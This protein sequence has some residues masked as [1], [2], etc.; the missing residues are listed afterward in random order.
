MTNALPY[1][2]LHASHSGIWIC[3]VDGE[4]RAI[5]KGEAIGRVAE[6]PHI[7]LN[8]PL[9]GQRL[10]YPDLS[11]LDLLELFAFIHP[12]QFIGLTPP[13]Q[14]AD[15]AALYR[16]AATLLLEGLK[17]P[18][19]KEREGAWSSAQALYRLR[20]PWAQEVG[21]QL[22]KPAQAERW[23]FS[24]LDE[25]EEEAPR[26]APRSITVDKQETLATLDALTGEGSEERQGQKNYAAAVTQIFNPR[27]IKGAPNMLLPG[28]PGHLS[29][30]RDIPQES[31]RAQGTGKLSLPAQSRRR[32][33]GRFCGKSGDPCPSGRALGGL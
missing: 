23:L 9:L 13:D 26:P 2:A 16:Q 22:E 14:E 29:G 27:K 18:Y 5:G 21:K 19:W 30:R 32:T 11:G 33:A 8:A 4:T 20:W 24:K 6:T 7:L 28:N 3:S 15:I 17:A 10:G 1:P 12:A 31:R 25:W